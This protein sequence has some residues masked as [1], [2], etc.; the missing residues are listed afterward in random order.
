MTEHSQSYESRVRMM[1]QGLCERHFRLLTVR[2]WEKIPTM[3]DWPRT[4]T[5]DP[6]VI[7]RLLAAD[8]GFNIGLACGPQPNGVNVVVVDIDPKNGGFETWAGICEMHPE[9]PETAWHGTPSGGRHVF[10]DAPVTVR[11]GRLGEG[12]DIRGEGGQVVLPPS[13]RRA[14]DGEI[15]PYTAARGMGIWKHP[16]APMPHWLTELCTAGPPAAPREAVAGENGSGRVLVRL[17]DFQGVLRPPGEISPAE[18]VRTN[19]DFAEALVE[20]GWVH[21][22]GDSW[23]RPG[24]ADRGSSAQ[25]HDGEVLVVFTTDGEATSRLLPVSH[26]TRDGNAI[27]VSLFEFLAA[28]EFDGNITDYSRHVRVDLMPRQLELGRRPWPPIEQQP[29]PHLVPGGEFLFTDQI[30]PAARWGSGGEVMWAAGES[31]I[32]CGPPATGKTTLAGQIVAGMCG[33]GG[34]VLG[35]PVTEAGKILYLAMDRPSQIMKA[36]RRNFSAADKTQ[37]DQRMV[38]WRGPLPQ[39][40]IKDQSQLLTMAQENGCDVVVID[41]LKD[42][43]L[44]LSEDASGSAVNRAIQMCLAEGIDVMALHHQR[45]KGGGENSPKPNTLDAVY[46]SAWITAGAGSVVLL[47]GEPGSLVQ[48]LSHLKSPMDPLGPFMVEMDN[49]AGTTEIAR[50]WNALAYL[51][52]KGS[53]GAS[54]AEAAHAEHNRD[55]ER[56]GKLWKQTERKLNG[57]VAAGRA[58]KEGQGRVGVTGRY[59]VEVLS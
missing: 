28:Y 30:E 45:K 14:L 59:F 25:L 11:N 55:V 41:S 21:L 4:A 18:W 10:F 44:N 57:L 9:L 38:F 3:K 7:A 43:C 34:D 40:L 46:G 35:Q 49:Y 15:L 36:L 56:G 51:S 42:L 8:A 32:I 23:K 26:P 48:E 53:N 22:G 37:L 19:L 58:R 16:I 50:Q 5:D 24:K 47:W 12:V 52:M 2:A 54:V 1:A 6:S 31:L 13:R 20:H 17:D 27:S 39:D 29:R 33:L